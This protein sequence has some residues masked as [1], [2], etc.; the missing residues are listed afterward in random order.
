MEVR[1]RSDVLT[2]EP[3]QQ[4]RARE[5]DFPVLGRYAVATFLFAFAFD[6]IWIFQA[7]DALDAGFHLTNQ[8]CVF[9]DSRCTSAAVTVIPDLIGGAWLQLASTPSLLWSRLGGVLLVALNALF[10]YCTLARS[11]APRQA[12]VTIAA[13][14]PFLTMAMPRTMMDYDSL[15]A[16]FITGGL[17]VLSVILDDLGQSPR[18]RL[19]LLS[20]LLGTTLTIVSLSR[21]P[22]VLLTLAPFAALLLRPNPAAGARRSSATFL[23]VG[24]VAGALLAGGGLKSVGLLDVYVQSIAAQASVSTA[25]AEDADALGAAPSRVSERHSIGMLLRRYAR[26]YANVVASAAV[27]A[28]VLAVGLFSPRVARLAAVVLVVAACGLIAALAASLAIGDPPS[29]LELLRYK[30]RLVGVAIGPVIAAALAAFVTDVHPRTKVL[31]LASLF[32]VMLYPLGS[33]TGIYK[34]VYVMW[35][36]L[37]L[38]ALICWQLLAGRRPSHPAPAFGLALAV[39]TV[40]FVL[41][42]FL[43]VFHVGRDHPNRFEL[44]TRFKH[45]A[46]AGIHSHT[47]TTTAVDELLEQIERHTEPGD[48]ILSTLPMFYYLSGRRPFFGGSLSHGIAADSLERVKFVVRDAS[49]RQAYPQLVVLSKTSGG[50]SRDFSDPARVLRARLAHYPYLD[51][52]KEHYVNERRYRLVWQNQYFAVYSPPV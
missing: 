43:H 34:S 21:P 29:P 3:E 48:P 1:L 6:A 39:L 37:P 36:P 46:L 18:R 23:A 31:L 12:F 27:I 28:G 42:I 17:F 30:R 13:L 41:G 35:I 51:F 24:L 32:A 5:I 49:A 10:A 40:V 7:F 15:P 19:K 2:G 16:L 44:V 33:N 14:T 9:D 8:L 22:L 11:F 25:P 52:L 38:A 26:E 45:P 47:A 50:G 4:T 20:F